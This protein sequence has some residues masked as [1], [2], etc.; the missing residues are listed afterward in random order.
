MKKILVDAVNTF[1]IKRNE[2]FEIFKELYVLLETYPNKKIILTNANDE[3]MEKFGLNDMPYEIFTLKHD[4][5]KPDH[6]YFNKMLE[7]FN[8][9]PEN[10]IYFEHNKDAVKSA[11]AAG[12]K[13]HHY[14]KDKQDLSE[15]KEFLDKNIQ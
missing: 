1:L 8:L 3:Q 6:R 2:T 13:T 5:D 12:I 7:H 4:P 11:R 10:C 9:K 15:L 14:D